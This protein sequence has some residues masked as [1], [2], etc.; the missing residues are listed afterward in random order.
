MECYRHFV[1][2][3]KKIEQPANYGTELT[4]VE[5]KQ[6]FEAPVRERKR[7]QKVLFW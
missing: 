5:G 7:E 6:G 2:Y 3:P 4:H 1:K